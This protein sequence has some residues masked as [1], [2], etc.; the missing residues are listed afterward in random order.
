MAVFV[1]ARVCEVCVCTGCSH[2]STLTDAGSLPPGLKGSSPGRAAGRGRGPACSHPG[3]PQGLGEEPSGVPVPSH[4]RNSGVLNTTGPRRGGNRSMSRPG[5]GSRDS[6]SQHSVPFK[7]AEG[8]GQV[9]Y[10]LHLSF[11]IWKM[12]VFTLTTKLR[13]LLKVLSAGLKHRSAPHVVLR[14]SPLE[15]PPQPHWPSTPSPQFQ[16]KLQQLTQL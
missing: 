3:L 8:Q 12:S 2:M 9:L 5:S 7:L 6:R 16:G 10:S 11:F 15:E 1:C 4:S 14:V 13:C